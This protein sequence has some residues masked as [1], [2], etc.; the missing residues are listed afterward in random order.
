MHRRIAK[1]MYTRWLDG[2]SK[3]SLELDYWKNSASHGKRFTAYVRRWLDVETERRSEQTEEIQRLE[4]L[5]R[6]NGI[7]S[8]DAGDL[9]EE[10]HLVAKARESAFAA[11]R[12]YNDPAARFRTETF[13]VLM[14]IAWNT[15]FQAIL[16]RN[17]VDYYQKDAEGNPILA[18]GRPRVYDTEKLA[19]LAMGLPE[20]KAVRENLSFFLRLRNN[21]AHRYVPA[22]DLH[23]VSEAQAMLLNFENLLIAEFGEEAALGDR[24]TVPLQLSVF[25]DSNMRRSLRKAQAQLPADIQTFLRLQRKKIDYDV[26]RSSE[27]ALQIFFVPVTANRDSLADATVCFFRPGEVTP[28]IEKELQ[29]LAVVT[30]PK[31]IPVVSDDLLRPSEVVKQVAERLPFKFTMNKHTKAWQFYNVRPP[32]NAAD[33]AGTN[34]DFCCWD[35]LSGGYGYKQAWVK[36]LVQELS[37]PKTYEQVV[38]STPEEKRPPSVS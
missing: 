27:Y 23:V 22:V 1:E 14:V 9:A 35:R 30:K 28:E 2:E 31:R 32:G 10:H 20:K 37:D 7:A 24:L 17:G 6:V 36:K 34:K 38:G 19:D 4:A 15:V 26:L 33:P 3:S 18:D 12:I 16:E 5:L 13:I 8:T 29:H 25:R 11:V 21:I